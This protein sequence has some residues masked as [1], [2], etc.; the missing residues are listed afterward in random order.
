MKTRRV[1]TETHSFHDRRLARR[2]EE[3]EFRD[4]FERA[5]REIRAIDAIVNELDSLR[6]DH[7]MTKADLARDIGK[8]PATVRRLFT[9]PANPELRTLVAMADALDADVAIVPR[10]QRRR[11]GRWPR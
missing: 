1:S 9:A 2:L 10:S 4:E 6:T 3:P 11:R 7:G 5:T 8:N